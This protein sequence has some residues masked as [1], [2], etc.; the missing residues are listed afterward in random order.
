MTVKANDKPKHKLIEETTL[1]HQRTSTNTIIFDEQ[2]ME[3]WRPAE[4][5]EPSFNV[6]GS[7]VITEKAPSE[8]ALIS[9]EQ[10]G[11]QMISISTEND[12]HD[13]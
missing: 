2:L 6:S 12:K 9:I 10:Q 5:F 11:V 8:R 3:G 13:G 1:N 4:A 7:V